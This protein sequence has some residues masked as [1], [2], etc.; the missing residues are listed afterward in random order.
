VETRMLRKQFGFPY[1]RLATRQDAYYPD[2]ASV[3]KGHYSTNKASAGIG[4]LLCI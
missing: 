2:E 4:F 3:P 1:S